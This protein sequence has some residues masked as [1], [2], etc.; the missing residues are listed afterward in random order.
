MDLCFIFRRLK[1]KS[2]DW[3]M[4]EVAFDLQKHY[5]AVEPE[6]YAKGTIQLQDSQFCIDSH[7]GE[8]MQSLELS[9]CGRGEQHF[10]ITYHHDIRLTGGRDTFCFDV[11]QHV[12]DASIVLYSCHN[13]EGNQ[14]F[15]YDLQN[16]QLFHPASRMCVDADVVKNRVRMMPCDKNADGQ[17]WTLQNMNRPALQE[18]WRYKSQAL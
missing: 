14:L 16:S 11:P 2:F 1:C 4:K 5:P 3:F 10:Q 6:P 8:A 15:K 9:K 7:F 18:L 12:P 17:R 13:A